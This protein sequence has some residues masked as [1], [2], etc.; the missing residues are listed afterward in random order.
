[1]WILRSLDSDTN[2][3]APFSPNIWAVDLGEDYDGPSIFYQEIDEGVPIKWVNEQIEA[4]LAVLLKGSCDLKSLTKNLGKQVLFN[5]GI[6]P[7]ML[8]HQKNYCLCM[9]SDEDI[10][11]DSRT[12]LF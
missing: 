1:M 6:V 5:L 11:Q 3:F 8:S 9:A 7:W 12:N 10:S 2:L 4:I